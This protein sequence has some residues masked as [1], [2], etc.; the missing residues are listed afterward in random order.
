MEEGEIGLETWKCEQE[1]YRYWMDGTLSF[2]VDWNAIFVFYAL[3]RLL[4]TL[5]GSRPG[6]QQ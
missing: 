3:R 5:G 4:L 6:Y 1:A 2:G